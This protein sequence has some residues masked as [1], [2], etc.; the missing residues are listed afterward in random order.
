MENTFSYIGNLFIRCEN[1]F[2]VSKCE[3]KMGHNWHGNL[4][5]T[6]WD[7]CSEVLATFSKLQAS[8]EHRATSSISKRQMNMWFW[9]D[10]FPENVDSTFG[11]LTSGPQ[12]FNQFFK[13][14]SEHVSLHHAAPT[15]YVHS[16]CSMYIVQTMRRIISIPSPSAE[17]RP[18]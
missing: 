8:R 14:T 17:L 7:T 11:F 12:F 3:M 16:I 15:C 13:S 5:Y 6:N 18:V 9:E 1:A 4:L 2:F 10:Y